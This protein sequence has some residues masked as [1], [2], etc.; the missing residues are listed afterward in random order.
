LKSPAHRR[1]FL[2]S[3]IATRVYLATRSFA[4]SVPICGERGGDLVG[5]VSMKKIVRDA[6]A[7]RQH[8]RLAGDAGNDRHAG[9]FVKTARI[10]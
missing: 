3:P 5:C 7:G 6:G 1:A 10:D 8:R 9:C 2:L 4:I